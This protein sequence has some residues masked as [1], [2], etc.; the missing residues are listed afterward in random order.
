VLEEV[1]A[2]PAQRDAKVGP[3]RLPRPVH[4]TAHEGHIQ[5]LV[6]APLGDGRLHLL[7]N[8][9]EVPHEPP[10]GGTGNDI[11]PG[12]PNAKR[13]EDA[14][15]HLHLLHRV[16]GKGHPNRIANAI[17]KQGANPN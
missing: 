6:E 15:P 1:S 10:A 9:E 11:H 2:A 14:V 16:G 12:P 5:V 7:H 3:G 17:R 4:R 13:L 8:G